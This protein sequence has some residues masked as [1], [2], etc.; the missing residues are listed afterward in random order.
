MSW[1]TRTTAFSVTVSAGRVLMVRHERLG[2]LRWELPGGHVEPGE[3]VEQTAARETFEE[4]GIRVDIA[5]LVASCLHEWPERKQRRDILFFAAYPSPGAALGV[6]EG[7]DT[8]IVEVAWRRPEHVD[9]GQFSPFIQPIV[10]A[11]PSVLRP[12][13]HPL[14]YRA[15]HQLGEDGCWH[16]VILG[17]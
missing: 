16:P 6:S 1:P 5:H 15:R 10:D 13:Q 7:G 4:T 2:V 17:V 8:R 9:R 14:R 12:D 11:W 3:S